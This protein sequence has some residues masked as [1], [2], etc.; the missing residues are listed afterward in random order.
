MKI[1]LKEVFV[2]CCAL[3]LKA[4]AQTPIIVSQPQSITVNNASAAAF[5]VVASNALTYQWQFGG[6]PVAG[7]TNSTL[8]LDDVSTNQA[9]SYAVIVT[10]ASNTSV[11][12]SN[13]MLTIVPGTI[14]QWTIS[15]YPNGASSNFLVQLFDHDKPATVQNFLHYITSGAYSNMFFDRDVTNFVLQGGD[16]ASADRTSNGP[17]VHALSPGTNFPAQVDNEFGVGPLIHNRFGTLA[18]ALQS[19]ETNSATTAFFFNTVDNSADLDSQ[20]FTVFGRILT[21]TNILE[22]FN[23]LSAPSGGIYSGFSDVPTLPVNYDGTNEPNDANFFYC[24]FAFPNGAP[25]VVTNPPTVAITFPTPDDALTNSGNVTITGT[26]SDNFGGIAEVYCVFSAL[27]GLVAGNSETNAALG[28][29]NWYFDVGTNPPGAYQLTAYAEDGAGN[30][31]APATVYF[32]NMVDLTIITNVNGVLTTNQ[33]YLVPGQEYSL[34]AVPPASGDVFLHWQNQGVI[35]LNPEQDVS[36]E[37]NFTLTVSFVSTNRFPPGLSITSPVAGSTNVATNANITISGTLPSAVVVDQVTV[38]LFLESNAVTAALPAVVNGTTW[39]LTVKD[40][41]D[42]LYT[43]EVV[44]EDASGQEGF[45]SESFTVRAP[46]VIYSEPSSIEALAGST[47]Y[48]TVIA[49]NVV[50]YQWQLVGTGPI[51]GAT[52]ATL[53]IPNV[54]A[55]LTGSSYFV[56]LTSAD[57]ETVTSSPPAVLTVEAGTLVQITFSGLPQGYDSNVIVQLFDHEKPATVANFLHYI[58]PAKEEDLA[59]N[60][61]FSNMIWD[62]CIPGFILEGGNYAATDRT[63]STPPAH[64]SS[65]YGS[66]TQDGGY[67]PPFPFSIDSEFGVGPVIHNTFGT[68]AMATTAGNS[69]SAANAFF[70]NL[71]DNSTELDNQNGGYTVFGQIISGSNVLQYFN[72]LSKPDQGIFDTSTADLGDTLPDLPVDYHGWTIPAN[73][74]LFFADFTVLSTFN[75]DTNPPSVSANYPTNGQTVSNADVLFQGTASDNVGVARVVCTLDAT[76]TLD[77]IGTTNWTV[78]FGTLSPG[79]H[80]IVV[81]AQDGSGNITPVSNEIINSFVVPRFAFDAYT[82][83]NGTL[84]ANLDGTNTSLGS[85]YSITATANKGSVFVNWSAGTNSYLSPT[86][87]F[88]MENGLQLTANFI[89]NVVS[90]GVSVAFPFANEQVASTNLSFK[91]KVSSSIGTAQ[92]T[93]Q[94]FS[95]SN[96]ASVLA[97]VVFSA[98]GTWLAPQ[99]SLAPGNYILQAIA[100]GT[101]GRTAV[102]SENFTVLAPLAVKTYGQGKVSIANGTFLKLGSPYTISASPAPG[103][104][105]LSW[106]SGEGSIPISAVSFDMT[107]GLSLTATFI[108]NSLPNKLTFTSPQINSQLTNRNITLAGKISSSVV[109]PQVVCEVFQNGFPVTGFMPATVNGA[110]WSVPATNLA[111]GDY[112]AVAIL[113]DATG[114]TTLASDKFVVNLYPVIEGIYRGLFFDP[115]S[116]TLTNAGSVDFVLG[117]VGQMYGSLA[118]GNSTTPKYPPYILYTQAGS[119]GSITVQTQTT[120]PGIDPNPLPLLTF[121]FDLTNFTGV[122]TGSV[123]IGNDVYPM[124]AYRAVTKLTTNTAPSPGTY[125]LNLEPAAAVKGPLGESFA[126]VAVSAGGSLVLAGTL[127][128]NTPVSL[129][130]SVYTNGVWP[131]FESFYKGN[132]MLIGWETNLPSG[133]CTGTLYWVKNPTNGLYETNGFSEQLNSFGT[134]FAAPTP[135]TNYMMVFGGGS[136]ES[137]VTNFCSFKNGAIIPASGTNDK[138]SGSV[139]SKGVLKGTL[140]NPSNGEKLS[141]SGIFVSP[142]N[143]G[144]GFTLDIDKQTGYFTISAE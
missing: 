23:T 117:N 77:A 85:A 58:T 75:L 26:A 129:L 103:Y 14:V 88:T 107:A 63:N 130:T 11:L 29:T 57:G 84:S 104:S 118:F 2:L 94:V 92:V 81:V 24:D 31:S 123:T 12:S 42:G 133:V 82:N 50:S 19:G 44:A 64:L 138:L 41:V 45:A 25:P 134:K 61:A 97:P 109:G 33:Q 5:T 124:T 68:L 141:F 51:A 34:V 40:L 86:R 80:K 128:D 140:L 69:N 52:N 144:G 113:T 28:T 17:N 137:P 93:C 54:T 108:S 8:S 100:R 110:S 142:T 55:N 60:V 65:I 32:T 125:A 49:S 132:A 112:N 87:K 10:G 76:T 48:F 116:V 143:G 99:V 46:P 4:N 105:F 95:T 106:N 6:A 38:Q 62:T 96:S 71:A 89:S 7:A 1:R 56:V 139:T 78:D 121:N 27:S 59:T 21:G 18:M 127:S 101:N 53:A 135:G 115:S 67:E 3:V 30:V 43:V 102:G 90:G 120:A 91:G 37:T 98:D 73:A 126:N 15:T 119:D 47:A 136:I 9:G 131:V 74:G 79:T 72:T 122:M 66:F 20:D 83:G 111:I 35:S 114:K 13:A 16:Y 70:F 39:S 36:S 22:Y